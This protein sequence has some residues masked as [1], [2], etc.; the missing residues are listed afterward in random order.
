MSPRTI[1]KQLTPYERAIEAAKLRTCAEVKERMFA[2][3]FSMPQAMCDILKENCA[4]SFP[5]L[6]KRQVADEMRQA[7]SKAA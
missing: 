3:G 4:E 1:E 2:T 5:D 7:E 6:W